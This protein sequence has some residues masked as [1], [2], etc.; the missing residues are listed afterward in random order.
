MVEQ[1]TNSYKLMFICYSVRFLTHCDL[2]VPG[3]LRQ[4]R[5]HIGQVVQG[6]GELNIMLGFKLFSLYP[7]VFDIKAEQ[8][9]HSSPGIGW[10]WKK[11]CKKLI[12]LLSE[13][14]TYQI[15]VWWWMVIVDGGYG[16]VEDWWWL[17]YSIC[18]CLI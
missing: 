8:K 17:R 9:L 5:A 14:P 1:V 3:L 18:N 12:P 16:V 2:L 6:L 4:V 13:K 7:W 15:F 10:G 11:G